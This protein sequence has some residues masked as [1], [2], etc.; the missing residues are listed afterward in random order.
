MA[1]AFVSDADIF[2]FTRKLFINIPVPYIAIIIGSS[3]EGDG[4]DEDIQDGAWPEFLIDTLE[5]GCF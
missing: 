4:S 3:C 1:T 2:T 5:K